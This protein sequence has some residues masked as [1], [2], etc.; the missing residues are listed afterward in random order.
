MA[1]LPLE[2]LL[3]KLIVSSVKYNCVADI[4]TIVSMLSVPVPFIRPKNDMKTSKLCK[5]TFIHGDSDHITLLNVYT[6]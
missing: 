4:L 6:T 3:A 5:D 1:A 2:P